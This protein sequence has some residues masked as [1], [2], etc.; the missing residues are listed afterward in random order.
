MVLRP[1][2]RQGRPTF[3]MQWKANYE[4]RGG[5]RT[6]HAG[7]GTTSPAVAIAIRARGVLATGTRKIG[8]GVEITRS[9]PSSSEPAGPA[10]AAVKQS[11]ATTQIAALRYS[12]LRAR[13]PIG[14]TRQHT[15]CHAST[16]NAQLD[17]SQPAGTRRSR[18]QSSA[19]DS[20]SRSTCRF[21][22]ARLPS[23]ASWSRKRSIAFR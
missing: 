19:P 13:K 2:R 17:A 9:G 11:S 21:R 7:G 15:P 23:P 10:R 4:D 18:V 1:G 16:V 5:P 12:G 3:R 8:I 22:Q 6:T 20:Q 14:C